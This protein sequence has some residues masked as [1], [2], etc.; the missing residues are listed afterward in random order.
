MDTSIDDCLKTLSGA[1]PY[2]PK[3]KLRKKNLP[4]SENKNAS[5]WKNWTYKMHNYVSN[6]GSEYAHTNVMDVT[7]IYMF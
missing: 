1:V 2:F 4:V 6:K 3:K 7:F 5:V